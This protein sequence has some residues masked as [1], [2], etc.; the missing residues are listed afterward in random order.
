M[1]NKAY[2]LTNLARLTGRTEED[3][4]NEY[5]N[6]QIVDILLAIRQAREKMKKREEEEEEDTDLWNRVSRAV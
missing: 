6:K 3:I 2:F 4:N 1:K 5:G